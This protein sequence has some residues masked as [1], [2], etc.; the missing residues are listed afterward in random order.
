MNKYLSF[1]QYIIA[2]LRKIVY[3]RLPGYIS[4]TS[5]GQNED[6][7]DKIIILQKKIKKCRFPMGSGNPFLIGIFKYYRKFILR[8]HGYLQA[9][10]RKEYDA[11]GIV[12][13]YD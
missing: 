12:I 10:M 8:I 11:A 6:I 9:V 13:K 2:L 5:S 1:W 4:K 3:K 7:H